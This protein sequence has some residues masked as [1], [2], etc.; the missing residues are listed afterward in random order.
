MEHIKD[1][2]VFLA[3]LA[4]GV[5]LNIAVKFFQ[6]SNSQVTSTTQTNNNVGGSMAGRDISTGKR[7]E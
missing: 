7:D 6:S 2:A 3:G 1:V 5:T 4:T